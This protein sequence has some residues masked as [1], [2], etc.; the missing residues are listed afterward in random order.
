MSDVYTDPADTYAITFTY[1]ADDHSETSAV[2]GHQKWQH[3][4]MLQITL[5]YRVPG[6][7]SVYGSGIGKSGDILITLWHKS[8]DGF[9]VSVLM[10]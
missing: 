7:S 6:F 2:R 1:G 8:C 10:S 4:R 9:F 3:I 5:S